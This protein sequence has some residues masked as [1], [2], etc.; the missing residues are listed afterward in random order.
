MEENRRSFL[1]K[2]GAFAGAL[3]LSGALNKLWAAEA[4]AHLDRLDRLSPEQAAHDEDFWAWIQQS[5]TTSPNI[6]NLNNGGVSPQPKPVQDAM[7]RYYQLS[8]EAPSYYMWQTL[9]EGRE[10]VRRDLARLAGC[11][12]EEIAINRNSTEGLA[13]II[14]GLRLKPGD[15]VVLTKQDYPNMI[16]AW[17]MREKRDGIKLNWV[18]FDLPSED[19][20]Y[21]VNGYLNAITERTKVVHLTH[22]I[23][24]QGQIMP[25]KRIIE[26]AHA[27]GCEVVLD[28]AHS[29]GHFQFSFADLNCDYSASSL[30]KWL[31]APF[32]AGMLYVK[33]EKI[34]N[35]WPIF[36]GPDPE[37]SDIRKFE[38]LGTRSFP[39]EMAVGQAV[40]FHEMIGGERKEARLRYLK[41]Y[42]MEKAARIP[43]AK[44]HTSLKDKF[45]CAIGMV[46]LEGKT[47]A[48]V[49]NFLN[50]KKRIHTVSID[51]E[52]IKGVRITPHVYIL[53]ADLD[54]L[55]ECL[56]ECA[57]LTELPK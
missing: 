9:D 19:E 22:I 41:N 39:I 49:Q 15:E 34:A 38:N 2:M 31:C 25:A 51:W 24:W 16:Q 45:S 33:K 14:L 42:W 21:L 6:L 5:F 26:G 10:P 55:V 23:N 28:A 46:S 8:N 27:R 4:Q 53:P 18:N 7:I 43:G 32:G 3:S 44:L 54:Y 1:Q 50:K 47:P 52:N 30:H 20:D 36:S 37:S 56:A 13:T 35:L 48:E 11:T 12:P 57:S 29:F 17:K 40:S